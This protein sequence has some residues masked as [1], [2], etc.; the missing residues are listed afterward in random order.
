MENLRIHDLGLILDNEIYLLPE[1]T[2]LLLAKRQNEL[3]EENPIA[4]QEEFEEEAVAL[5]Y[6]GGF[7]KGILVIYE[8]KSLESNLSDYLFKI[9]GAVSCSPKDIALASSEK[10]EKTSMAS[11]SA[12]NPNRIIVFGKVRHEIMMSVKKTY[13]V[14]QEDDI[15]YLFADDLK[16]IS[17]SLDLRKAL[18]KEL[19]VLFNITK[20]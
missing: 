20:K 3:L 18:W 16:Q 10:T 11:I 6:E 7:E 8:G 15:E 5:E 4:Q 9:L 13:E 1:E 14:H 12:L 2:E 19:Q 17:E